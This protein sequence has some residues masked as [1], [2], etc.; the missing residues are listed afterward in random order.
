MTSDTRDHPRD[1]GCAVC[2]RRRE[3]LEADPRERELAASEGDPE[4][5]HS[6]GDH[7]EPG[8]DTHT[9][10]EHHHETVERERVVEHHHHDQ[11]KAGKDGKDGRDGKPHG[12]GHGDRGRF[13]RKHHRHS[14]RGILSTL[15]VGALLL[16]VLH[17]F[18]PN[19]NIPLVPGIACAPGPIGTTTGST[20]TAAPARVSAA[21]AEPVGLGSDLGGLA[22]DT[23]GAVLK[24]IA[25]AAAEHVLH[26][27]GDTVGA[28][29]SHAPAPADI[30]AGLSHDF[31]LAGRAVGFVVAGLQGKSLADTNVGLTAAVA[32]GGG[33]CGA[34]PGT[35]VPA[36]GPALPGLTGEQ[37][38]NA[39]VIMRTGQSMRVPTRGLVVALAAASQESGIRN[40][41]YGDRDSQGLFQMRPSMGWGTVAQVTDPAYASR[42]FFT[43][44]NGVRGWQLMSVTEAAQAVERSGFPG[45]YAKWEPRAWTVVRAAAGA[46][47]V[48]AASYVATGAAGGSVLVDGKR[49]S[50]IAARQLA[51]A[52]RLSGIDMRVVQGGY[53][54]DH[55]AASG[56]S[57][58]YPGVMD[59]SPGTIAVETVL[60][61]VGFAA[62]ARN[63][64]G[65]SSA[66]SGAH[67]HAVS[68]L[69][70]GDKASPQ[71]YGS[72][73][74]NGNGLSGS[75]NDPAAHVALVPGLSRTGGCGGTSSTPVVAAAAR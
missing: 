7:S 17:S 44:L 51:L 32:T 45:A 24:T 53:G 68:L 14:R 35:A 50:A 43:V 46:S 27:V 20:S 75:N 74:H 59:V 5:E 61:R 31:E 67:V 65:R 41:H 19:L 42:K 12:G 34:C 73:A 62:W 49:V 8:G 16:F 56:S 40:L 28:M 54:G 37:S 6:P 10:E 15:L 60:R 57:H 33:G 25:V 2:V 13:A 11:G 52:E 36:N 63:I 21:G 26:A 1:C 47:K 3:R 69:D 66:G 55:I 58:N 38:R 4:F 29:L 71:V 48:R 30:R 39:Y 18:Y 22:Q 9:V 64:P 23:V 70:P 72:W